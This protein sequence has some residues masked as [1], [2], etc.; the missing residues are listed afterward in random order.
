MNYQRRKT[1]Q[2]SNIFNMLTKNQ[3]SELK[4]AFILIDRDC[5]SKLSI[6]DLTIFL[7]SLGSPYSNEQIKEMIDELGPNPTY[8]V[9]LT[10][11]GERMCEID[12]EKEI[13]ESF[14][15]FDDDNDGF[16]ENS[17]L[18][19]S[20]VVEGSVLSG[21]QYDYVVRGCLENGLV[22]YRKLANKMKHGEILNE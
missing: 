4:E 1:R 12:D 3:L 17:V 14:R 2:S 16:I 10:V 7:E 21:E 9:L 5:D 22:N 20:M 18:K 15:I 11:I 8:I 13:I 19:R 6:E